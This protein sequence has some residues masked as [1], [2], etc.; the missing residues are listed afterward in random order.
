VIH[1]HDEY[2]H[3]SLTEELLENVHLE[4]GTAARKVILGWQTVRT[5]YDM[6]YLR[7]MSKDRLWY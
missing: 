5:R 4:D 3:S 6:K 7:I 1:T 2:V